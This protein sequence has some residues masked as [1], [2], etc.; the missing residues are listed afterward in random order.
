MKDLKSYVTKYDKMWHIPVFDAF[1]VLS[2]L[3]QTSHEIVSHSLF[4]LFYIVHIFT[5]I[6]TP[7]PSHACSTFSIH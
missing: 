1:A 7:Y 6:L 5:T 3:G 2:T 4:M